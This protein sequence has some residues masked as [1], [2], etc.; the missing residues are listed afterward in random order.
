MKTNPHTST[1]EQAL[2]RL[3]RLWI[4]QKERFPIFQ[5]A[6]LVWFFT[7]A[8]LC[9]SAQLAERP[10]PPLWNFIAVWLTVLI[11]FFQMRAC[12]EYKDLETDTRYR[13]E[14]AIPRGLIKLQTVLL[15]ALSACVI[16]AAATASL[17]PRLLVPLAL[18]WVW[19]FV[20]TNEFFVPEWLTSKPFLYLV[21]HM[22]IM[23]IIDLYVS[24]AE[25]I[26]HGQYPPHGLWIFLVLSF[27]NGCVLEFGRKVWAPE[28]ERE[29]VET[30]SKLLGPVRA[31]QIWASFC[32]VAAGFLIAIAHQLGAAVW[33][34]APT[35]L[36]IVYIFSIVKK[37]SAS[38][39]PQLQKR[40]D[41]L[42]GVWVLMC[43][44]LAGFAPL[45]MSWMQTL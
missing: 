8:T 13:P 23:P 18:V 25:W 31:A 35:L 16:A 5:T 24:G 19:L 43:Y 4:Y 26:E 45:L 15:I 1:A 17:S 21:S 34:A 40:I 12:D 42:S 20:M 10:L 33:V 29:G 22:M 28:N 37:F 44:A 32:I 41:T 38:P 36:V 11:I 2:G 27:L 6:L 9:V 3:T 7:A 30:Y 39:N 14:R